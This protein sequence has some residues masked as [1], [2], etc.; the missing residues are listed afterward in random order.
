MANTFQNL[1]KRNIKESVHFLC[2]LKWGWFW[3]V[4]LAIEANKDIAII[5]RRRAMLELYVSMEI[6]SIML[7]SL[8]YLRLLASTPNIAL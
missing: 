8:R 5:S 7:V 4:S 2:T 6:Q 3:M 1:Q